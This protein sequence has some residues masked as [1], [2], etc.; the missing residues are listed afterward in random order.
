MR[1]KS[2]VSNLKH[3]AVS[4]LQSLLQGV[5]VMKLKSIDSP[6]QSAGD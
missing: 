5:S 2:A 3:R 4:A 6:V 1:T